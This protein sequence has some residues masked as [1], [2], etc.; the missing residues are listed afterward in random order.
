LAG[1]LSFYKV[2]AAV[3]TLR[4]FFLEV[5]DCSACYALEPSLCGSYAFVEIPEKSSGER[6]FDSILEISIGLA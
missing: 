5:L 3:S 1:T 6:L 4:S 2:L